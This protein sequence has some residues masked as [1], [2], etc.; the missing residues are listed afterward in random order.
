MDGGEFAP[1]IRLARQGDQEVQA[2]A[3]GH[4]GER[5]KAVTKFGEGLTEAWG[6]ASHLRNLVQ[7]FGQL[8]VSCSGGNGSNT[9]AQ[10]TALLVRELVKKDR[11]GRGFIVHSATG[12]GGGFGNHTSDAVVGA[13][14]GAEGGWAR[15]LVD[16]PVVKGA[17]G[18]VV[19][20]ADLSDV[21]DGT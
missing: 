10:G 20:G 8:C 6:V 11:P 15:D 4:P 14:T 7:D 12:G 5:G 3:F 2:D 18:A 21:P 9:G 13:K 17:R 16:P 19:E 1:Q